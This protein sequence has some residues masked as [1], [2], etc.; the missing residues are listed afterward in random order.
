MKTKKLIFTLFILLAL[1]QLYVPAKM[2]W[3]NED[4]IATGVELKFKTAPI[5]PKDPFR[6]KYIRLNFSDDTVSVADKNNWTRGETIYITL[7]ID[8][9][10]FA[11][12]VT[13]CKTIPSN[14]PLYLK[15]TTS[16]AR[17]DSSNVVNI[18]YPF[19]RYY[20]EET[21]AYAAEKTYQAS[22]SD[23]T[24]IT[25]ALVSIK[26]GNAVLK[27]VMIDGKSIKNIVNSNHNN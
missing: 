10:G 17:Y 25:Y 27:D 6:G 16:Y 15:A 8:D 21:K 11:Q 3:N 9:Q 24:S 14:V 4:I 5:D 26:E 13:G 18:N 7:K 12:L 2:I 22:Q 19:D 23:T 20:M 1:V